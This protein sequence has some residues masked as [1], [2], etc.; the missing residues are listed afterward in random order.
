MGL[1]CVNTQVPTDLQSVP[2]PRTI[3]VLPMPR[4]PFRRLRP[5][6]V[7][8]QWGDVKALPTALAAAGFVTGS[9]PFCISG[10]T[11]DPDTT[12]EQVASAT[13]IPLAR[14]HRRHGS[15]LLE[16][17]F[18]GPDVAISFSASKETLLIFA[19]TEAR[20]LEVA[21]LLE[22]LEL[23]PDPTCPEGEVPLSLVY[24]NDRWNESVRRSVVAPAW[25]DIR[26]NYA[27]S[28]ATPIDELMAL[29][30]APPNAGGL[31]LLH[32]PSGTGKTT[33]LRALAR[34][35][36]PW[37]TT[38][39]VLDPADLFSNANYLNS[40]IFDSRFSLRH[41]DPT[42]QDPK[43]PRWRLLIIEDADDILGTGENVTKGLSQLL[44]LTDGLLGHE[45][46]TLFAITTNVKLSS[47]HPA[48]ARPG[49]CLAE[50][51]VP[52]LSPAEARLWI[53]RDAK[54][55]YP[56]SPITLAALLDLAGHLHKITSTQSA[57]SSTG[58]YL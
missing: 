22:P 54:L 45:I 46:N 51:D 37:C 30:S 8:D 58:Q 17:A 27:L 4:S 7:I 29:T 52:K 11:L 34:A 14:Y 55:K 3:T 47:I 33:I 35:W 9:L 16:M 10:I 48:L 19:A 13:K 43:T 49:R 28:A 5:S 56:D 44:N 53:G 57:P 42:V 21:S 38:S 23:K 2:N 20:A 50:I 26:R 32:G 18:I 25:G 15:K 6:D 41:T 24:R 31:L 39:Y 12:P 1:F 36:A 40:L